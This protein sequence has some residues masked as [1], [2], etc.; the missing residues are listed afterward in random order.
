MKIHI[1]SGT[2]I[3]NTTLSAFD[4][5]LNDAGVANYNLLRLSSVI[6]PQSE[7]VIHE[8]DSIAQSELPGGW[9]DKLYVV[10]AEKRADVPGEQVW[11]GIGWVQDPVTAKGLFVEHE[12][13]S[14]AEV[15]TDIDQSLKTLMATRNID[16]GSIKMHVVGA[17]CVDEPICAL[18]LAVYQ[19]SGWAK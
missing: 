1:V 15:R 8:N 16:F 9:G 13:T 11:A 17:T 2:G 12:G 18:V 6:P 7:L 3:G 19:S 10:M 14:E 4:S 5:A